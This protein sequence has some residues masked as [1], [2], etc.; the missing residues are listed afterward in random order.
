M[1]TARTASTRALALVAILAGLAACTRSPDPGNR[2]VARLPALFVR[3]AY[4]VSEDGRAYAYVDSTSDG[5]RVVTRGRRGPA[6][7]HAVRPRFAPQSHALYYWAVTSP[8]VGLTLV[9][10]TRQT[11][12]NYAAPVPLALAP[13]GTRWATVGVDAQIGAG[14]SPLGDV[15]ATAE[16]ATVIIDGRE[17]GL[18]AR[19]SLP[20][21]SPD[22]K[23]VAFAFEDR[24]GVGGIR[25]DGEVRREIAPL[26][27]I[28][29][30][31]IISTD[32]PISTMSARYLPGGKLLE[33]ARDRD[34]VAVYLDGERL[35][36]Y[37]RTAR[38]GGAGLV[39]AP[40]E[41]CRVLPALAPRSFRVAERAPVAAWWERV[42]GDQERWRVVR[43]GQ[44][45]DDVLCDAPWE[46]EPPQ[47]TLD[48][49][50]VAYGC[51][52][53]RGGGPIEVSVVTPGGE[54]HGPYSAIWGV[55][56][57]DDGRRVGWGAWNGARDRGWSIVVDGHTFVDGY[58][59]VYR[60]RFT[61]DGR[62]VVWAGQRVHAGAGVLAVGTRRV[63]PFDDVLW[64]PEFPTPDRVAWIVRRG[65]HLVRVTADA[66]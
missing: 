45:V 21:F 41:D 20:S 42:A 62:Q 23:H 35:A 6:F 51:V 24:N 65:R 31:S 46:D 54:R 8:N 66:Q 29:K 2:L 9:G 50:Q 32:D 4:A 61:P 17:V 58:R 16:R 3:G 55:S 7:N 39:V 59:A 14:D 19:A 38:E 22:A 40:S 33:V 56:F 28:C 34:A 12:T 15:A 48:G 5:E 1:L 57:S 47:L 26:E 18:Y 49:T 27:G 11:A 30:P 25:V 37:P 43:N 63:A 36:S 53:E 52:T 44:P 60:P 10:P 13:G 64:G